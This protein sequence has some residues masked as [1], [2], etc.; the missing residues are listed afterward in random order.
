YESGKYAKE[1]KNIVKKR[2]LENKVIFSG[3]RNDW[4]ELL[5]ASDIYVHA[6]LWEG[7]PLAVIEGMASGLPIIQTDFSGHTDGFKNGIHGYIVPKGKS[8][9]LSRAIEDMVALDTRSRKEIGKAA[10]EFAHE[11]YDINPAIK[12]INIMKHTQS[13]DA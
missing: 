1:I 11:H 7:F 4:I 12:Y 3:W 5:Q 10:K 9:L 6:A 8:N 13:L 2:G